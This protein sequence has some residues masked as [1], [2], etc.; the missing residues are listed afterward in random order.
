MLSNEYAENHIL[1]K[2]KKGKHWK[3][4]KSYKPNELIDGF[5]YIKKKDQLKNEL[6]LVSKLK[7]GQLIT[8]GFVFKLFEDEK[9]YLVPVKK[10]NRFTRNITISIYN[11][12]NAYPTKENEKI[13]ELL[14]ERF[15]HP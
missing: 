7:N 6:N 2:T 9:L 10:M 3:F 14:Y 13:R 11:Y 15:K 8:Q 12:L 1:H 4:N 5:E